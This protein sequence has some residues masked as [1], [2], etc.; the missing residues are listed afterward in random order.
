MLRS[1]VGS[2]MCIRDRSYIERM[3]LM[4]HIQR[5]Y[6]LLY[7]RAVST[8]RV[9]NKVD[10]NLLNKI[11]KKQGYEGSMVRN[12]MP[13]EPGKRSWTLQKVKEWSDTEMIITDVI[14]GKGKFESG[15]GK[16]IG[17]DGDGRTVEVPF[18]SLTI[19]K[20]Q[21]MWKNRNELIGKELTFIYFER[22]KNGAYR[23]PKA[24]IIRDYE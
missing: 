20:R 7:T 1:L 22:T 18:P 4:N 23:F 21:E 8:Q 9:N 2:E 5:K 15:I 3:D 11:N 19:A 14:E 12:N 10:L 17:V 6:N 13:Y 16:L 24:K